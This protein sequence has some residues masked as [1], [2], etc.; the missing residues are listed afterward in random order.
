MPDTF[1]LKLR[2]GNEL[3]LSGGQLQLVGGAAWVRQA[4][5]TSLSLVKGEWFIDPTVGMPYFDQVLVKN[6]NLSLVRSVFKK[7]ILAVPHVTGLP[8]LDLAFHR[9]ARQLSLSFVATTDL[10]LV[11][12]SWPATGDVP[13]VPTVTWIAETVVSGSADPG[14][15][16]TLLV[17]G[18]VAG[19]VP[20]GTG[21]SWSLNVP[22]LMPGSALT[23]RASNGSGTS[24][25]SAPVYVPLRTVSAGAPNSIP[26]DGEQWIVTE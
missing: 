7:A 3:D 8:T 23:A 5:E 6:P 25:E 4:I 12:G 21:G 20:V 24:A 9:A 15:T 11:S 26:W 19:L 14:S 1:D 22:E 10:G 16:V 18:S 2:G 17:D 13:A